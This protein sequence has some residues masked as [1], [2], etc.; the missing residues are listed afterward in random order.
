MQEVSPNTRF[1]AFCD[2]VF[3][4]AITLL[5]VDIR[6]PDK[7]LIR[8]NEELWTEISHSITYFFS[9]LLSFIVILITWV[10]HH[11]GSHLLKK[12]SNSFLYANGFLLL[13]IVFIPYPT[14]L[15]GEYLLTGHAVP[16]VVLY[17]AVLALQA[18]AWI[19][20]SK[21][22]LKSRL[23]K[24]AKADFQIRKNGNYGY[25]AFF[26]YA[27]LAILAFWFPLMVAL[28]TTIT[29]ILWLILGMNVK[30]EDA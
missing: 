29:W 7:P 27:I 5:I 9:F 28:F 4:I 17:N 19:I 30:Y 8:S 12:T 20:V 1:E 2:G 16:A 26:L 13:T 11:N 15:L 21:T 14:S 24:D 23:G 3:A 6:L 22:A 25:A 18:M 10:N